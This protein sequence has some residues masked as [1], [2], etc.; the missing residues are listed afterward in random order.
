MAVGGC[1]VPCCGEC[2]G[3]SAATGEGLAAR[4]QSRAVL[5]RSTPS[6]P[7][8]CPPVQLDLL[9]EAVGGMETHGGGGRFKVMI[10]AR[11]A[12]PFPTLGT[13]TGAPNVPVQLAA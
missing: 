11:R 6:P 9:Q 12:G 2:C 10:L 5:S 4:G 3:L 8:V 1:Q 13:G 7:P